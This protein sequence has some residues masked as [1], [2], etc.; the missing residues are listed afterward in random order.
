M[1]YKKQN[2]KDGELLTA[3]QLNHIEAGIEGNVGIESIRQTETSNAD[4]GNNVITVTLT[5]GTKS[6]FAVKNGSKGSDGKTAYQ[7]AQDGGYT[8]TEEEF[9]AKLARE[10][11]GESEKTVVLSEQTISIVYDDYFGMCMWS[12]EG[13]ASQCTLVDGAAYTV[14]WNGVEY[15]CKA[16]PMT[17]GELSGIGIGNRIMLGE[18]TGEPFIFAYITD[19]DQNA[20]I[21]TENAAGT[22]TIEIYQ[23]KQELPEISPA[24][25]GRV[26]GV[27]DGAWGL[28][29]LAAGGSGGGMLVEELWVNPNTKET[30]PSTKIEF[31]KT[32]KAY[33]I[34]CLYDNSKT[35]SEST[36]LGSFLF[37]ANGYT[38][39]IYNFQYTADEPYTDTDG[40]N[41]LKTTCHYATRTV[42]C[43]ESYV[44]INSAAYAA[45]GNK[46]NVSFMDDAKA[47]P[48]RIYGIA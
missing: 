31:S 18:N 35:A 20:C 42:K 24:D 44:Q 13:N 19:Y 9:A 29:A 32:Y 33:I 28:M 30:F 47:I 27:V 40:N 4:G 21:S 8:G 25:N 48:Y 17:F 22:Y 15:N 45:F 23:G 6:I 37:V 16:E 34:E 2:F 1:S 5:D 39:S 3:A 43:G 14:V 41:K 12:T 26:L 38:R 10:N 7:Y 46:Q 11:S 36:L